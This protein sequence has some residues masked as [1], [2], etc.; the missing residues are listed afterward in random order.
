MA[1]KQLTR[2]EVPE[3]LTWDLTTIFESDAAW[4]E[5][6]LAIEQL[7]GQAENY[8]GKV[9]ES[10][11]TLY[12][13]LQFTDNL[14]ARLNKLYVYSHLKHDQ[15]TTNSTYQALDSRVKSLAAKA[16][17][18]WSFV[19]PE[20]LAL[21]EATLNDYVNG[22]EPLQLYAQSMK[23]LN[24][25]RP[26]ILSAEK[27]EL[28]AQLSEVSGASGQ[29]FSALNNADLEFPNVKNDEGEEVPLTHGSYVTFLESD[30]REVR[31]GAFKA[32]YQTYGQ[33]KNTFA[34]TLAGNVKSHNA[35]AKIRNF[36]SARHAAMSNN[37]IPEKVYDQLIS[38]IHDN[39]PLVHRYIALRKQ[40]LGLDELHMYDLFTPLVK[41]VKMEMPYEEAK[42]NYGRKFCA[43]R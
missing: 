31:E 25:G 36:E 7:S 24:L 32:M 20:I 38:T 5:E 42:K 15:D 1:K 8:K 28:L 26:H 11:Q 18:A 10:A 30:N 6:F 21:D 4:E 3:N 9:V 13:T 22:F 17:A 40:V 39:L 34:S 43:T 37:F 19:T 27:E 35:Q 2:N 12:D 23:E 29:T 14:F 33:F 41:E 16:G